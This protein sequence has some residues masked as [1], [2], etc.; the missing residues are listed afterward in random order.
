MD[1]YRKRIRAETN[2][3]DYALFVSFFPQLVAGPIECSDHLLS[4]IKKIKSMKVPDF[5]DIMGG[6]YLILWGLFQK[7]VIADR[8]AILVNRVFDE[9]YLYG[10]VELIAAALGFSLQI[11]CDFASYSIIAMG[12]A[13][14]LGFELMENF[15]TPYFSKSI[16]E[17]W[18]RW[19]ISLS[20]WF[21]DYLYIPLGGNRCSKLRH[22]WNILLVFLA[23]GL[24]HGANWTFLVWG[25]IHG[26]YQIMG[27]ETKNLKK[28]IHK[29]F[30]I[31]T[32]SF[33]FKLQQTAG[34][35]GLVTLSWIFFR[36][37]TL[38]DGILYIKRMFF[39]PN[40]WGLFD[41]SLYTLGLDV[42]EFHILFFAI[43]LMAAADWIRY[44]KQQQIDIFLKEQCFWFQWLYV[45]GVV[46]ILF[47][48]GQ[49]GP[50]MEMSQFIYFQF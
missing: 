4:Q 49:Y 12:S 1:V 45:I 36:S 39:H 40:L 43:G 46:W 10:S 8:I 27:E 17:F 22:Y 5:W 28:R 3:L 7:M 26:L 47:V 13:R 2:L 29:K 14:I 9:Y 38:K 34:T 20:G 37:N 42:R 41:G 19:H 21:T 35:V 30:Q 32:N 11:Y 24:W 16:K 25:G 23:S 33:S 18:H 48:F 44:Q 6:F 50:D 31:P 15:N